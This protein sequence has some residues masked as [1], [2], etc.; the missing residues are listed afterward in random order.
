M[1]KIFNLSILTLLFLSIMSCSTDDNQIVVE[2]STDPVLVAPAEG[3]NITI[4][5]NALE[6]QT[7]TLVWDHAAYSVETEID[8][9]IEMAVAGTDFATPLA[10]PSTTNRFYNF[11]GDELKKRLTNATD[12]T[13][14]PGL[15]LSD[16][17]NAMIE[18][19]ITATIGDNSDLPMVSNI[20]PLTIVFGTGEVIVEPTEPVLFLVGAPQAYYGLNAWDNTTAI[21]MRYIGDGTT[22]VF[23]AYVKVAAADGFKF[24]GE[25]GTWD[26]GNYGTIDG[27]QDGNLHNDGGSGDIKVAETDGDGQYYVWVDIDNLEY[28]FV[29]MEWGII[30]AATPGG[31]DNETPMTYDFASNT[32]SISATL[33]ADEMKFRSANTGNFIAS[34][35]WKFNIGN[36]DPMVTYDPSAPNFSVS[37]GPHDIELIVNFDGTATASG[38]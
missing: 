22:M 4:N 5:P 29:K 23:E 10:L 37:A 17:E 9:A 20:L 7:L 24:I 28:K 31:W 38:L 35:P 34:D 33:T 21:P 2:Q 12:D 16:E 27:A 3:A 11:T 1:K 36:S 15:G 30:G 6:A 14:L 19:R 32:W 18:V 26:N 13:N 25:Q 8:Y